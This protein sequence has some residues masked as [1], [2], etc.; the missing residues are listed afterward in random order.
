M[1]KTF[2]PDPSR[3]KEVKIKKSKVLLAKGNTERASME[4][5]WG[6]W[7][8]DPGLFDA[9]RVTR[10]PVKEGKT[11]I[12]HLRKPMSLQELSF[13]LEKAFGDLNGNTRPI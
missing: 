11:I 9:T 4:H 3:R 2:K 10:R 1:K 5:N 13:R 12:I 6:K 8:L 7:V